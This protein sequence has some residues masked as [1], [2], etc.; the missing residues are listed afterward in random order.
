MPRLARLR[1]NLVVP[2]L[3]L[4][5]VLLALVPAAMATGGGTIVFQGNRGGPPAVFTVA[6][7]GSNLQRLGVGLHPAISRDGTK[8]VFVRTSGAGAELWVLDTGS[9]KSARITD[10]ATTNAEPAISPDGS[11]IA[12]VGRPRAGGDP[13]E[14]RRLYLVDADGTHERRLTRGPNFTD[15]EPSFSPDGKRIVFARTS[16]FT[17]LMTVTVGGGDL[18]PV[19]DRDEPFSGPEAPSYSPDGDTIVFRRGRDLLTMDADGSGAKQLVD[20]E[21][22]ANLDPSW[23]R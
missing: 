1:L 5:A 19:T 9:G 17:Q 6:P 4:G 10:D 20:G 14:A 8:I 13:G 12:F 2:A 21:N 7:N 15:G 23:G 16:H 22:G 18:T 11:E 3:I